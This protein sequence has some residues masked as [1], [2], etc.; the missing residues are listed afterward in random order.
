MTR[1]RD[2]RRRRAELDRRDPE[3]GGGGGQNWIDKA[4]REEA[5]GEAGSM[6]SWINKAPRKK[7]PAQLDQRDLEKEGTCVAGST[8]PRGRRHAGGAGSMRPQDGRRR[9]RSWIDKTPRWEEAEGGA[10]STR[11]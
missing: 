7:A 6:G 3:T 5:G 9:R 1:P 8:K 10:G 11:P 4:L 2:G